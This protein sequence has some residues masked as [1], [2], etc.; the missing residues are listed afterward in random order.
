MTMRLFLLNPATVFAA[1]VN[2]SSFS[3]PL[4]SVTFDNVSTGT[5][6]DI[7]PGMTVLF[8][9]SAGAD[10]L[11]RQRIRKAATS[12]TLYIGRSSIG[13]RD[14]EVDLEDD[15]YI[16]VLNDYRV[17]A[18]IPYI[19]DDGT[20][21]K[22][23]DLA[24][25]DRTTNP[26]PVANAGCGVAGTIDS[27]TG[28]LQI[29]L[30]H[31]TNTSFVTASGASIISYSWTLPAGVSLVT[32]AISDSQI[33]VNC[34]PGFYWIA[35]TVTDSNGKSHTAR[36][37]VYARDP[38]NDTSINAFEIDSHTIRSQGQEIAL[39]ILES[40]SEVSYPDGTLIM[41]WEGKPSGPTDR[42]HMIFC[43]WHHTDP[44][45]ISAKKT[46]LLSH[47]TL[48]CLD[49]AGKLD[50]LP[51]FTQ[52]VED[53]DSPSAWTEIVDPNMDLYLHYLLHWHSTALAVADWTDSNTGSA[54]PFAVLGSSG[55][56]L[57]D[58]VNRRAQALV[59]D[60]HLTCNRLGQM[61]VVVD[62]MLQDLG[63]RSGTVQAAISE[64][65]W[66]SINWTHR[67][68][69]RTHWLRSDAVK[70]DASEIAAFFSVSP[71]D[72]PGQGESERQHSEQL[73]Q[74]Q[75]ALNACEGHRYARLNAQEG[76][77]SI[78]LMG[79]DDLDIEPA[80]LQWV[81][82]QITSE[83]AAERG[84][85]WDVARGLVSEMEIRYN[86]SKTGIVKDIS[87]RWEREVDGPTA[88][89]EPPPDP[90]DD[91]DPYEPPPWTPPPEP[92]TDIEPPNVVYVVVRYDSGSDNYDRIYRTTNFQGTSPA[93]ENVT[94]NLADYDFDED[95][96]ND[97]IAGH[98]ISDIRIDQ[99]NGYV[100][101]LHNED[102]IYRAGTDTST[103]TWT[104]FFDATND[105]DIDT[106]VE[107]A[108]FNIDSAGN[109]CVKGYR[110]DD[111]STWY[112][113]PKMI[114]VE[115]DGSV[116]ELDS[117]FG[118]PSHP[119]PIHEGGSVGGWDYGD[120]SLPD[121]WNV[122]VNVDEFII[123]SGVNHGGTRGCIHLMS[124]SLGDAHYTMS[125]ETG[126]SENIDDTYPIEFFA[127]I[128]MGDF[129]I[130]RQGRSGYDKFMMVTPGSNT[131]NE[132]TG[133][134]DISPENYSFGDMITLDR[135]TSVSFAL[136]CT[137]NG[138][139]GSW[140]DQFAE[141]ITPAMIAGIDSFTCAMCY[142]ANA[143]RFFL[144]AGN[145]IMETDD[146]GITWT[147]R[148]GVGLPTETGWEIVL[149]RAE[150]NVDE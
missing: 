69:P 108:G 4:D 32:G 25:S 96:Q 64:S 81:T 8:G 7:E 130:G 38:D 138:L 144:G 100:Y 45:S 143:D 122:G 84:Y 12:D 67:R 113:I 78:K 98:H 15:T 71:G 92:G 97:A 88:V 115:H 68:P 37:P 112:K 128:H 80:T 47:T 24:V 125:N 6:T 54:Y 140:G 66:Q 27:S 120:A 28:K 124:A 106:I 13:T 70:A 127:L 9:T 101:L 133:N 52:S 145:A 48:H 119:C 83:T 107:L 53:N 18:K 41:L 99:S 20:I 111:E 22:D 95:T 149:I 29:T 102:G 59:P 77:Y 17:W 61:N 19:A 91:G 72:S 137:A 5:Y 50:N 93:W 36:V 123:S 40:I 76:F 63:D 146:G 103:P 49:V 65:D 121:K 26:P 74:S 105:V 126:P 46:A 90:P 116:W 62:P 142:T 42:S 55:E 131:W 39:R 109:L 148:S 104:L 58:Q 21:Y 129:V 10:D 11:G 30:P 43:G 85:T 117:Q 44:V 87:L 79:S 150:Q 86:H 136:L 2:Q 34:D 135:D 56:S 73:A 110:P 147:N 31:E 139:Y 60:Y 75:S 23:S 14:G 35:L 16:T 94:E 57:F 89:T 3:Y 134:G 1:L 114:I 141:I 51:G 118:A 82:L 33:T 132:P